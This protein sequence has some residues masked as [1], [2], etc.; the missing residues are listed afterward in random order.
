[1]SAY[2]DLRRGDWV[3]IVKTMSRNG[4]VI[5]A[6]TEGKQIQWRKNVPGVTG[7]WNDV[8]GLRTISCNPEL[9]WRIKPERKKVNLIVHVIRHD[10][11]IFIRKDLKSAKTLF[12]RQKALGFDVTLKTIREVVA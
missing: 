6:F 10:G 4:D 5:K 1:M 8:I 3:E 12:E 2:K 7:K 11:T 9:E